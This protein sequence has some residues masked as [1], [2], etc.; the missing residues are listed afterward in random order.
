MFILLVSRGIPT[1]RDPQWGC[2]EKDQAEALVALGHKVVIASVDTRFRWYWR[3]LGITHQHLNDIEYYNYF[4]IPGRLL[5]VGGGEKVMQKY[6]QWAF[7]KCAET[8]IAEHGMP[9][10]VYSHY[11]FNSFQA[12]PFVQKYNLPFV[13]I[14]HWSKVNKDVLDSTIRMMGEKVYG[15]ADT[16]ITVS[17]SLRQRIIKHFN[18]ETT[19][20]HN[21]VGCE[22]TN[23]P[24]P[25]NSNIVKFVSV[26]TLIKL[27]GHDLLIKALSQLQLP[28]ETWELTIIGDGPEK[29]VLQKQINEIHLQDRIHLVGRKNKNEIADILRTNSVF[30]LP[31]RTENFSVAV[32][33]ALAC[34]LPVIAS[35]CGGIRECIDEKNGL[36]F[37][38][39]D[40]DA[41][42]NA[43]QYMIENYDKY[44]RQ[45][46]A[47]D[48]KNRFSPEVIAKQ[49]TA[50]FEEAIEKHNHK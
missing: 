24:N 7:S 3:S 21:M 10:V 9:D 11:L 42:A 41:L 29:D 22:F 6:T 48:C 15:L 5:S 38:V 34:G 27:K 17:D 16:I 49:L 30:V 14:E 50:V 36:L 43:L 47:A 2:F 18:K 12:L 40:V 19:V 46:I 23:Q 45:G 33:E 39:D 1:K 26:G 44:D 25:L 4:L 13:A 20:V 32:L 8:I 35:I 37:P 28:P 31:S